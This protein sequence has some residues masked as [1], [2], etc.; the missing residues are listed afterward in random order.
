MGNEDQNVAY[1]NAPFI[2]FSRSGNGQKLYGE[3]KSAR[4]SRVTD[5]SKL[6]DKAE[7]PVREA[8]ILCQSFRRWLQLLWRVMFSSEKILKQDPFAAHMHDPFY[9]RRYYKYHRTVEWCRIFVQR[10]LPLFFCRPEHIFS[11]CC[12]LTASEGQIRGN[13]RKWTNVLKYFNTWK[14]QRPEN[15][16]GRRLYKHSSPNRHGSVVFVTSQ[17]FN[18]MKRFCANDVI[19]SISELFYLPI[20]RVSVLEKVTRLCHR[21]VYPFLSQANCS[22]L[23]S[24]GIWSRCFA[25]LCCGSLLTIRILQLR[26]GKKNSC[27]YPRSQGLSSYRPSLAP[28]GG[29]YRD[30]GNEVVL[31]VYSWSTITFLLYKT[32]STWKKKPQDIQKLK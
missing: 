7:N 17:T 14:F 25:V 29:K 22:V 27:Q 9:I 8:V 28:G 21:L 2:L 23:S 20:L 26:E 15:G 13:G 19:L 1:A 30:P 16:C 4:R 32:Y 11:C 6:T 10:P 18:Q 3:M 12:E 31:S 24:G 5:H